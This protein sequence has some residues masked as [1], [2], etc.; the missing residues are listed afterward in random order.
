MTITRRVNIIT[1]QMT[2]FCPST[3]SA[4]SVGIFHFYIS[5]RSKFSSMG[6][7][8]PLLYVLVCKIHIH[9]QKMTLSSL[10]TLKSIFYKKKF[11]CI[12]CFVS[13]LIL[14]SPWSHGLST[15]VKVLKHFSHSI[16]APSLI[17]APSL[18]PFA[19]LFST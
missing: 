19:C 3:L 17:L 9:M 10:L 7:L 2:P 14:Y 11:C 13:N 4:L 8:L 6:S 18:A 16:P 1:R 5:M 15:L 12:T